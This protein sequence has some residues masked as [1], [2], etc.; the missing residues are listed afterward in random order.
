[1]DHNKPS[2]VARVVM[3]KRGGALCWVIAASFPPPQAFSLHQADGARF[4]LLHGLHSGAGGA[5]GPR[6]Q[7]VEGAHWDHARGFGA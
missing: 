3:T 7:L 6:L 1:V 4:G 2:E 5:L